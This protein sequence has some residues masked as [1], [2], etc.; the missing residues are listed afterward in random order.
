[1]LPCDLVN[2]LSQP[3]EDRLW[4][5]CMNLSRRLQLS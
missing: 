2:G 4:A 3:S 1:M 5:L